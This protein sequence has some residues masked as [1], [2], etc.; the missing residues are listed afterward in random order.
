MRVRALALRILRQFLRDRRTLALML[1]APLLVL[2]LMKLV[3]EGQAVAPRIGTVALPPPVVTA[4]QDAG[5]EIE[6]FQEKTT[7]MEAMADAELDAVISL[8]G[9]QPQIVLE[10]SDP[11]KSGNVMAAAQKA[12]QTLVPEGAVIPKPEISYLHGS[13]DMDTF[14]Y[15]GSVLVGFFS[16]FFVFLIAGVSFLRERTTGTLQKL[17]STPLRRWEVVAGYLLGFG[18]FTLLQATLIA[19]YATSILGI[20]LEGSMLLV[21]LM[22]LLLAVTALTLGT[23]M[24]AYAQN[25]FQMFQF[26]PL[27]VVPQIFF[28]GL[29]DLDSMPEWLQTVG[30]FLPLYYGASALRGIMLRGDGWDRIWV[31]AAALLGFSLLFATLNVLALRKHRR[32]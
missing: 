8:G 22:N 11:A 28:C 18:L 29:I 21:L 7:A 2:T 31:D 3:F 9:L 23:L 14:D 30:Q 27:V 16:F 26:I 32:I 25:E 20:A 5:A 13:G 1:L 17:L 12:M 4:L 19:W 24:S 6:Q 15:F 10:G